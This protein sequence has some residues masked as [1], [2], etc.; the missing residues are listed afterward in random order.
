MTVSTTNNY[1]VG[2]LVY[3]SIPSTYGMFQAN[4][5]TA[6]IIAVNGLDLTLKIDATQFDA[7]VSPSVGQ[8]Q[9]GT[10]SPAGSRNIFNISYVPFHSE[11]NFG[12]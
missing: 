1:V 8:E 3:L 7:F 4:G 11:G 9:P 10:A 12:N 2:Q 6:E 5:L